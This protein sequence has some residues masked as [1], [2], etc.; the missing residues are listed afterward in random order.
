VRATFALLLLVP[1][2][3]ACGRVEDGTPAAGA[4]REGPLRVVATTGMLADAVQH[5]GGDRVEVEA[6]MGPGVDPHL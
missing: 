2:L 1:L 5:V 3:A 4:A 6:L